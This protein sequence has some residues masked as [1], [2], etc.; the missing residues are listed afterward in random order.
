MYGILEAN[1]SCIPERWEEICDILTIEE[2]LS[3]PTIHTRNIYLESKN[4]DDS[5]LYLLDEISLANE[6]GLTSCITPTD[7]EWDTLSEAED[8]TRFGY[9]PNIERYNLT[10]C[11]LWIEK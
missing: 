8:C 2:A 1:H 4:D 10:P 3:F 9:T 5:Y 7:E 11:I 6:M